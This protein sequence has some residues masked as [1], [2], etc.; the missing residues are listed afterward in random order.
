MLAHLGDVHLDIVRTPSKAGTHMAPQARYVHEAP[1]LQLY[2][3]RQ[4]RKA[5]SSR[6]VPNR[7]MGA[8]EQ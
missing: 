7:G 2:T 8:D 5:S 3:R 6:R 1:W 4:S